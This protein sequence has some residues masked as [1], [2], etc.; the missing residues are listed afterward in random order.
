MCIR[1]S[2]VMTGERRALQ[3]R[4]A[5]LLLHHVAE[6]ALLRRES[7][8]TAISSAHRCHV[9]RIATLGVGLQQPAEVA[10]RTSVGGEAHHLVLVLAEIESQ[11][12][13]D[14]RIEEPERLRKFPTTEHLERAPRAAPHLSL[15][16]ISEPTR[17]L[18]ISY[19]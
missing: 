7:R 18:S 3:A 5:E 12:L 1:D 10:R 14:H 19:A 6:E 15:I 11:V 4:R 16:H 13:C 8:L 2:L 9:E 17:L